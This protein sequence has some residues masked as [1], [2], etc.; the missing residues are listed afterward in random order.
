MLWHS[1]VKDIYSG[2]ELYPLSGGAEQVVFDGPS[3]S[4]RTAK[5]I[6]K[7]REVVCLSEEG[8][9]LDVGCGNGAF[10][11]SFNRLFPKW[12]LSGFETNE[13]HRK[14]IL[15]LPGAEGFH[16]GSLDRVESLF[17]IISMTYVIEHLSDPT[18][19]MK[20]IRRLL[21]PGGILFIQTAHFIENPFDLTVRDHCSHFSLDSL[22]IA[23]KQAGFEPRTTTSHWIPKEIG[24]VATPVEEVLKVILHP[25]W[26]SLVQSVEKSLDW[27]NR[28]ADHATNTA[29]NGRF[30]IFG[31]AIAG[32]WLAATLRE[33][34][35]FFVD[36]DPLRQGKSH[37][38]LP[39]LKLDQVPE[40]TS[41][42]LAF[43]TQLADSIYRRLKISYPALNLVRPP[44]M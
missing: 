33:E 16:S 22:D 12:R 34:V 15:D 36:E 27:L 32:T 43:P 40:D 13:N 4:P 17:D 7:L 29:R 31:T 6:E 38:G 1:D 14:D 8:R 10:L 26:S 18:C 19:V 21:N 3:P 41:V 23:V 30:G 5:I 28:V 44:E 11:Q 42:Y 24:L 39:V 37:L 35:N 25:N 9:L 2:Y 20:T